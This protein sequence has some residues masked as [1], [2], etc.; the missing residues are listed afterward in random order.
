MY[1]FMHGFEKSKFGLQG[2][3]QYR[4]WNFG[5]DLEQLLLRTAITYQPFNNG[6]MLSLGY[7]FV[8]SGAFGESD[9]VVDE[10]RI[11]QEA[12]L[13]QHLGGRFYMVHRL[14]YEQR[15]IEDQLL[16]TRYRYNLFLNI[17]LNKR[18]LEPQAVYLA[19]YNELFVNGQRQA[20]AGAQVELFDRNRFYQGLGYVFNG[21]TRLQMGWMLQS[22]NSWEKAQFQLSMHQ[23]W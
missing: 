23:R 22:T 11:Y 8:G 12:L 3:Y 17:P 2:D 16:R 19:F 6:N 13:P 15:F 21:S 9:A 5:T 20:A 7:A 1:Y 10:H 18:A 14:R 4:A